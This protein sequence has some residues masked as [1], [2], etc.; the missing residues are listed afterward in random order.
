MGQ[1]FSIKSMMENK[2]Q[3]KVSSYIYEIIHKTVEVSNQQS[4]SNYNF[5]IAL[6]IV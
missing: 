5:F 2:K 6:H 1:E 3:S 4:D